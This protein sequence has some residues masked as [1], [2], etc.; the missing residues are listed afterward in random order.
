VVGRIGGGYLVAALLGV[1][2]G[3]RP[4]T[5]R[6]AIIR[7][8]AILP[9]AV[10]SGFAGALIVDQGIGALTGHFLALA[11]VGIL[12]VAAAAATTLALQVLFG[13]LGI[14]ITVL[15]FVVAGNPSAGGAYQS[16]LLPE[17]FRTINP[18]LPNGAGVETVRR[19]V[20]FSGQGIT[21]HLLV[22]SAWIVGGT[23]IALFGSLRNDRRPQRD[24]RAQEHRAAAQ[25]AT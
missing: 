8:L 4:A 3:A 21:S 2:S 25:A 18:V 10:V 6:R 13:V 17:F 7:L 19:I 24:R 22:I 20:Y 12:L 23:V 15:V 5:T 16:P 1:A 14:G 11:G 9:Y